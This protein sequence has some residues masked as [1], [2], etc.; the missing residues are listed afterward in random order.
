M[1]DPAMKR[2]PDVEDAL[3]SH[4]SILVVDDDD[5]VRAALVRTL[6]SAG[7][8]VRDAASAQQA[9]EMLKESRSDVVLS[10]HLMPDMTG[11]ELLMRVRDRYPDCL[12]IIITGHAEMKVA[13]DAI[14]QGEVYRFI[15]KPWDNTELKVMLHVAFEYLELQREHRLLLAMVRTQ[16]PLTKALKE[17]VRGRQD[18]I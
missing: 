10:D 15:T 6:H 17:H 14:N 1:G 8:Q 2:E 11:L 3:N 5:M 7:Y 18:P 9:L 13:I 16:S 12:R 4:R